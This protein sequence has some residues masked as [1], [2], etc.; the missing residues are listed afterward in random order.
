MPDTARPI[1]VRTVPARTL[2][3]YLLEGPERG[4]LLVGFHGYGENAEKHLEALRTLDG[5]AHFRLAAVQALHRFYNTRT[6][7]VVGSW[8]TRLDREQAVVDNLAY[9]AAVVDALVSEGAPERLVFAGFSQGASMAW[10]AAARGA[11]PCHGVIALGGDIPPDVA[12][13]PSV[14]LPPALI[15]RGTRDG[16]Y[17][18]MK[19]ARDLDV[20]KARGASFETVVFEGG[21]EWGEPFLRAAG[22]FLG[23]I[24]G[25]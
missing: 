2:G 12:E 19:M 5:V 23:R 13:D 22:G 18:E 8:M 16:W 21:H 24:S 7:E 6:N 17:T 4:P 20:L 15:G 1:T 10:R 14:A 11:H 25:P 9:V 3:R